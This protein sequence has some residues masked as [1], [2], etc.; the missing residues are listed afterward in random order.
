MLSCMQ[1]SSGRCN[2]Y[3]ILVGN[4]AHPEG[5]CQRTCNHCGNYCI[6]KNGRSIPVG[7]RSSGRP[8]ATPSKQAPSSGTCSDTKPSNQFSCAQQVSTPAAATLAIHTACL[9]LQQSYYDVRHRTEN[10]NCMHACIHTNQKLTVRAT[11]ALA[12]SSTS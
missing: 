9:L 6:P 1:L 5:F 7:S 11:D 2:T 12:L 3:G 4:T 8:S 10:L